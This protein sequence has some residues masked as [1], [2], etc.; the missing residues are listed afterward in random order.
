MGRE[1]QNGEIVVF[2]FVIL[3]G[4]LLMCCHSSH[5]RLWPFERKIQ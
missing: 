5:I 4:N 1:G 3:C 2:Y